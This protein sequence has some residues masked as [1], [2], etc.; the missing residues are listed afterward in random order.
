MLNELEAYFNILKLVRSSARYVLVINFKS[1]FI[2]PKEAIVET[3]G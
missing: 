2:N 3:S 1:Q